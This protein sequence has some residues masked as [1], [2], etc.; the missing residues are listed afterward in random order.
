MYHD[1]VLNVIGSI[2]LAADND[3]DIFGDI[4]ILVDGNL[5]IL[6]LLASGQI[7][8]YRFID[9]FKVSDSNVR[10]WD[11]GRNASQPNPEIRKS[12]QTRFHS[13]SIIR[14]LAFICT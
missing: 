13:S 5:K 3:R 12:S 8:E 9:D 1:L 2:F 4:F 14:H 10:F 6:A 7:S 11:N